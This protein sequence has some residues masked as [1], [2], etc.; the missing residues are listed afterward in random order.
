MDGS[1]ETV[2]GDPLTMPLWAALLYAALCCYTFF[3]HL[4]LLWDAKRRK[5]AERRAWKG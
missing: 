2:G 3:G 1:F 5:D 4:W